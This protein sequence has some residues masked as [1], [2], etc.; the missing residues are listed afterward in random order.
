MRL[1][2][3]RNNVCNEDNTYEK[4][5]Q[6]ALVTIKSKECYNIC[7]KCGHKKEDCRKNGN[8]Y[9]SKENTGNKGRFI[10]TCN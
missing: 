2:F 5:I 7:G 4:E 1:K 10:G 8:N 3:E 6:K 9:N